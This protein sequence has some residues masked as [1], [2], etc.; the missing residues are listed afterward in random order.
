MTDSKEAA[1]LTT[2]K[3][4]MPHFFNELTMSMHS[5]SVMLEAVTGGCNNSS[6]DL[7]VITTR[8][9]DVM[10][11]TLHLWEL[12]TGG[13][14][15]PFWPYFRMILRHNCRSQ[16]DRAERRAST[17]HL[18]HHI[19][20]VNYTFIV[21][22]TVFTLWILWD[23]RGRVRISVSSVA[24]EKWPQ[25]LMRVTNVLVICQVLKWSSAFKVILNVYTSDNQLN[26]W[27]SLVLRT[28]SDGWQISHSTQTLNHGSSDP[29]RSLWQQR[30]APTF[31]S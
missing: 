27:I 19:H 24:R 9:R 1:Q 13:A 11:W 6:Y 14:K 20:R 10:R 22:I 28:I 3:K 15:S 29:S 17:S 8:S 31:K 5:F 12:V 23:S 4:L 21:K 18:S 16:I 26:G 2:A 30:T 7:N 25:S